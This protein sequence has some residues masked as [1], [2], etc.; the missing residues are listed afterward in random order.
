LKGN[1]KRIF[2]MEKHTHKNN[3]KIEQLELKRFEKLLIIQCLESRIHELEDRI[4]FFSGSLFANI[5]QFLIQKR[6][7]LQ[8]LKDRI[9]NSL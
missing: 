7:D 9:Y 2:I 1:I 4:Q 5:E 8:T 3:N 6:N